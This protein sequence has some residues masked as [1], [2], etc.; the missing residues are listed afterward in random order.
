MGSGGQDPT[1]PKKSGSAQTSVNFGTAAANQYFNN[2]NEYTRDGSKTYSQSN[3]WYEF[4]DS[5]GKVH[6]VNRPNVTTKL[7][8]MQEAIAKQNDARSLSMAKTGSRLA[9]QFGKKLTDNFSLGNEAVEKRIYELGSKRV[10]EDAARAD[11]ALRTRLSNQGIK[12]GSAA[13]DNEMNNFNRG[14]NDR[15]NQLLLSGRGQASQELIAEDNQRVNQLNA[16]MSGSQ[17]SQPTFTTGFNG[18][19][20]PGVDMAGIYANYDSARAKNAE[21]SANSFGQ[22]GDI[23]GNLFAG[24]GPKLLAFSD[25]RLKKDMK[26]IG[27]TDDGLGIFKYRMKSGGGIQIGLKAQD[28]EK[29]MPSAVKKH[30]SGYKMVD[31]AK[32]LRLGA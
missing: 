30:P 11:E 13:Y 7:S 26:K 29:K 22:F 10:N 24:A 27:E 12:V 6:R 20:M 31:Y 32:A 1:D 9:D 25:A 8:F 4:T 19:N 16:I 3:D 28:V 23:M 21:A 5:D 15:M 17:V 2:P 18:S 14:Q